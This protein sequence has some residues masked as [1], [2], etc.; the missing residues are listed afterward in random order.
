[1]DSMAIVANWDYRLNSAL[2]GVVFKL[3]SCDVGIWEMSGVGTQFSFS[4]R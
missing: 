2:T 1:M 3:F 4:L